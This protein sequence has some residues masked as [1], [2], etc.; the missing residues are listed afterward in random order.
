MGHASEAPFLSFSYRRSAQRV[1]S[2]APAV[3]EGRPEEQEGKATEAKLLKWSGLAEGFWAS[4]QLTGIVKT[5][6]CLRSKFENEAF[7]IMDLCKT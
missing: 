1:H 6:E 3:G 4:P 2:L 7:F 5:S